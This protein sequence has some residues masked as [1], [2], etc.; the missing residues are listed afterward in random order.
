MKGVKHYKRDGTLH[1]GGSHKMP[2]G[3]LH[4]N[5]THTK[6]SVKLFHFKDLSKK[7]KVKAKGG[8]K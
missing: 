1:K 4:T 7:A 8:K 5:K 3:A 2:N 6:T